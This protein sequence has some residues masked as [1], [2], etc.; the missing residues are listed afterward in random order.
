MGDIRD[1]DLDLLSFDSVFSYPLIR[2]LEKNKNKTPVQTAG[3]PRL[4]QN[5][6][7][8]PAV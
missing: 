8:P 3:E 6:K 2:K 1:F 7:D 4:S 5:S